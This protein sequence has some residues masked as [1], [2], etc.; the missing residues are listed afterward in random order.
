MTSDRVRDKL[1]DYLRDERGI[2]D[3]RVL[4]VMRQIPRHIFL[5]EALA[6]RAYEDTALPI[7]YNQT[8]SQP[9]IVARMTE[10]LLSLGPRKKVLEIGKKT[11]VSKWL[12]FDA[13]KA[14]H[15]KFFL[16]KLYFF[17][18]LLKGG[19][20]ANDTFRPYSPGLER[21]NDCL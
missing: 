8:L 11:F 9:Y 20:G 16:E 6:H 5:D 3:K 19:G 15:P 1:I 18:I 4:D 10:V 13:N 12:T 7:G 14:T 17:L 21:G 2:Q